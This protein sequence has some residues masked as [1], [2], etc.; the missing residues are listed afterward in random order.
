MLNKTHK[1]GGELESYV[2]KKIN[3]EFDNNTAKLVGELGGRED[4]RGV[5]LTVNFDN[6]IQTAQVKP[7]LNMEVIEGMYN[8]KIKGFIKSY[9]TD[10][11]IVSNVG[12][13]VYIFKN[14]NVDASSSV[15][16]IPTENLI[17]TLN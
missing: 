8:V 14:Q 12:Q 2:A 11:I 7:L 5:D 9:S 10:L 13:P 15:F 6:K 1:K 3:D 17:Y 4:V 16:K